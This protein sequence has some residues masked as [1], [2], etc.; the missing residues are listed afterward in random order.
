M[1]RQGFGVE[2]MLESILL[3]GVLSVGVQSFVAADKLYLVTY[4][5]LFHLFFKKH[6]VEKK[7]IMY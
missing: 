5:L 1:E 3:N 6:M 2:Q 4:K 7:D